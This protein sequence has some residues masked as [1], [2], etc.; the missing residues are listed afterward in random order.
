MVSD[1]DFKVLIE[2]YADVNQIQDHSQIKPDLEYDREEV[3]HALEIILQ[4]IDRDA[5]RIWM[6][7]RPCIEV[8]LEDNL[9]VLLNHDE[10][11]YTVLLDEVTSIS[12][13]ANLETDANIVAEA[14]FGFEGLDGIMLSIYLV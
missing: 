7:E 9:Q 2:E 5:E 11:P 1:Q 3:Y 14:G 6:I 13:E 4:R 12:E 10:S 8:R